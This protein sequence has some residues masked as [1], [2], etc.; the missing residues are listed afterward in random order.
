MKKNNTIIEKYMYQVENDKNA[1]AVFDNERELTKLEL[2]EMANSISKML[3]AGCKRVGIMMDHSV[4]MIAAIFA[5]LKI[6]A[7]YIPVEPFFP[8]ERIRFMMTEG[9][10]DAIITNSKYAG[11]L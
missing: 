5:V 9:E 11:L 3:P 7:A 2:I 1:Y 8:K 6:G 4:E 10:A